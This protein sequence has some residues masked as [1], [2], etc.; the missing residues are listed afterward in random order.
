MVWSVAG[1]E[2]DGAGSA[3]VMV[4]APAEGAVMELSP[5]LSP[6]SSLAAAV[7]GVSSLRPL[8]LSLSG[9]YQFLI[10]FG[11]AKFYEDTERG[12]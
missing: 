6:E 1:G 5:L 3:L 10:E 12:G 7:A 11:N 9:L 2:G 8:S 4:P